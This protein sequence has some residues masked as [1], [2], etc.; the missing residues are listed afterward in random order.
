MQFTFIHKSS[1]FFTNRRNISD[2]FYV[3]MA[4]IRKLWPKQTNKRKNQKQN[5]K[6]LAE[7]T[8]YIL[9][10]NEQLLQTFFPQCFLKLL[11]TSVT[12]KV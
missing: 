8:N 1:K 4:K 5:K 12:K 3:I 11:R 2:I 7:D 9:I 10:L 6:N